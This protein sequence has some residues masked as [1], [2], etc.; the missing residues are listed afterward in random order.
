MIIKTNIQILIIAALSIAALYIY[1][2]W[3]FEKRENERNT[4]NVRQNFLKDSTHNAEYTLNQR[5]MDDYISSNQKLKDLLEKEKIKS[6][7]VTKIQTNDYTY[8]DKTK[9]LIPIT[10]PPGITIKTDSII[11]KNNPVI[12]PFTETIKCLTIKGNVKFENNRIFVE[13]TERE[14]KNKTTVIGYWERRQWKFLGI[15]TRFLGK[16]QATAKVIN[17][18][19]ESEIITLEKQT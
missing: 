12:V 11:T 4:E 1:D 7:R 2:D 6:S 18:C 8:S 15:K 19:G 16:I 5:Q 17:E 10:T 14:F 13:L 3:K 9:N